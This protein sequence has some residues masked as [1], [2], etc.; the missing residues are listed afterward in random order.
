VGKLQDRVAI[1]TGGGTGIGKGIAA[2]FLEEGARL[3]LAQRRVE[4]V[5]A[6]ARELDPSGDRV[7]ALEADISRQEAVA[8][9]VD[10]ALASFGRLDI[11][12]NNA[13]I[14]G[15]EALCP[16]TEM[17]PEFVAR[18]I[19]VNLKGTILCSQ[20]AA[21]VMKERGGGTIL[22]VSSV[23]AFAGQE[24]ASVYCATK[25]A[26]TGLTQAMALELVRFG[27]RVNCIA[28]GD[29][30]VGKRRDQFL[31][32]KIS[33]DYFRKV[34]AGRQGLPAE[35]GK[36]AVSLASDDS[37]YVLGETMVVDGGFLSY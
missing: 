12:V 25:A 27:I 1:V 36:A 34:P 28:P 2:C 15:P 24:G 11:L 32:R 18:L 13:S 30:D 37:S 23:G 17:S 31:E 6:A 20:A 33:G 19:D 35:I 29:I 10:F 4:L 22:H 21:R 26:M 3:V 8:E 9:L 5:R 14:T 7:R 16:F